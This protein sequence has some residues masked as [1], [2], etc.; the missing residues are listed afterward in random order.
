MIIY[1]QV[2]CSN[3]FFATLPKTAVGSDILICMPTQHRTYS[4]VKSTGSVYIQNIIDIFEK[5]YGYEDILS[6]LTWVNDA[7]SKVTG[8]GTTTGNKVGTQTVNISETK[9]PRNVL[10][11]CSLC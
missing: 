10:Q 4:W 8:M 7:T 9:V 1:L 5:C 3:E 11:E 2:I 6:M